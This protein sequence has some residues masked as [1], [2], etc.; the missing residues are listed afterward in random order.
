MILKFVVLLQ[1]IPY[2]Y[3]SEFAVVLS[4]LPGNKRMQERE[5]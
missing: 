4:E 2:L 1:A 5:N 3:R